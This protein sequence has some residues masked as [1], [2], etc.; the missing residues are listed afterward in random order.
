MSNAKYFR[1]AHTP[2]V[3]TAN[4]QHVVSYSLADLEVAA[5]LAALKA[6]I[7]GSEQDQFRARWQ[8]QAP[9]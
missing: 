8:A 1:P 2:K 4:G 7:C 6:R 3:R 5:S 9:V